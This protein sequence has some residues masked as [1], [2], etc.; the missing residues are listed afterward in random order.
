MMTLRKLEYA[1]T[2]ESDERDAPDGILFDSNLSTA[3][4]WD[5]AHMETLDGKEALHATIGHI[6]QNVLKEDEKLE[7]NSIDF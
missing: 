6:Y 2:E 5:D 1:Y 3:S 7:R 4:V